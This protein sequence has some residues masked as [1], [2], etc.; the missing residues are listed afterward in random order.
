MYSEKQ[1]LYMWK[2][3]ATVYPTDFWNDLPQFRRRS[4]KIKEL[5]IAFHDYLNL[6]RVDST[7]L[8]WTTTISL[9]N[10]HFDAAD[11]VALSRVPNLVALGLSSPPPFPLTQADQ[12]PTPVSLS[13]RIIRGWA[14]LAASRT[15]FTHLHILLLRS[16][17]EVSDYAFALLARFPSLVGIAV[18]ECPQLTSTNARA[19]AQRNGW[20]AYD[21]SRRKD[22]TKIAGDFLDDYLGSVAEN[23]DDDGGGDRYSKSLQAKPRL[24][25]VVEPLDTRRRAAKPV[26]LYSRNR[27]VPKP[28]QTQTQAH[29]RPR[30]TGRQRVVKTKNRKDM[31]G[32]LAE[33]Q[34]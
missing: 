4:F 7:K 17:P 15:A 11:L 22:M 18:I 24:E 9:S 1:T 29:E 30:Q 5:R 10:D 33:L 12:H 2:L 31:M 32:L 19:S 20:T 6:V 21:L 16:Q 34:G 28:M 26:V 14:D 23:D 25:F 27:P 13:D 3:L 8:Y